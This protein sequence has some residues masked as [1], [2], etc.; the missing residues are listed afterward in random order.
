MSRR[1]RISPGVIDLGLRGGQLERQRDPVEPK[2]QVVHRLRVGVVE[3]QLARASLARA[4]N[5]APAVRRQ[6]R[7]RIGGFG[8]VERRQ[9]RDV[10]APHPDASRLVARTDTR[11]ACAV[12]ALTNAGTPRQRDARS[13]RAPAAA[14]CAPGTAGAPPPPAHPAAAC[15][16]P[17]PR[18]HRAGPRDR[19]PAAARTA[20]PRPRSAAAARMP[21]WSARRVLPTPPTPTIETTRAD[22]IRSAIDRI[23]SARPTKLLSS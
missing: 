11:A 4:T 5:N 6:H 18:R 19:A 3:R 12:V 8:H 10:L 2:A 13:C 14:P 7:H 16:R 23:S 17:P 1:V 15:S 20:R 22:R 21:T 9:R